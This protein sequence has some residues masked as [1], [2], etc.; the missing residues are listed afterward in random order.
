MIIS[1][2]WEKAEFEVNRE[3]QT[4]QLLISMKQEIK[5]AFIKTV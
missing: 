1:I 4:I 5:H 2:K 3:H